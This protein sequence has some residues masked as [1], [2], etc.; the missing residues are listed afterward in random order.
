MNRAVRVLRV[1]MIVGV[2]SSLFVGCGCRQKVTDKVTEKI[3]EKV[4]E[5]AIAAD[6]KKDGKDVKVDMNLKEGKM[7]IK[8]KDDGSEVS[9]DGDGGTFT[10]KSADGTSTMA[11]GKNAKVPGDFPKDLPV[12]AG[13]ITMASSA[14]QNEMFSIQIASPDPLDKVADFYKKELA[15]KGWKEENTMTQSGDSPLHMLTYSKEDRTALVMITKDGDK[16][17][18]TVQTSK[19]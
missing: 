18:I 8:S 1:A 14:T 10:T 16:T 6:A 4:I 7:T 13:E 2:A 3:G 9:I 19:Q 12:Y 17:S 11:T 5:N 15:A